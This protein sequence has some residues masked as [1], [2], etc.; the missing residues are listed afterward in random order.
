MSRVL[1]ILA[2]C[3]GPALAQC[4]PDKPHERTVIDYTVVVTCT[5]EFR[6]RL[7]CPTAIMPPMGDECSRVAESTCPPPPK[8]KVCLSDEELQQAQKR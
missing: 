6:T 7:W 8:S 4:P 2:L 5:L 1:V 3:S